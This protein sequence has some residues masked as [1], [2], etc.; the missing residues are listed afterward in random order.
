M[1]TKRIFLM[2]FS[3]IFLFAAGAYAQ[4]PFWAMYEG[5]FWEYSGTCSP[6]CAAWAWHNEVMAIDTTTVPGVTTYRL[7]GN[8]IGFPVTERNWFEI[9]PNDLKGWRLEYFDD[10]HGLITIKPNTGY[11][12]MKNPM[13]VPSNWSDFTAGTVTIGGTDYQGISITSTVNVSSYENVTVPLG[14]YKAYK[15]QHVLSVLGLGIM[16]TQ[17]LWVVPHLGIV[18]MTALQPSGSTEIKTLTSMR[19]RK[20]IFDQ[21]SDARTDIAIYQ[22]STGVWY[23][24]PSSGAPAYGVGWGGPGFTPVPGDYDGDGKTDVAIYQPTTGAW[25]IIPSSGAPGYGVGWGGPGFTPVPGDYDGDGKTDV[26]IYQAATGAWSIIPSSGAPAFGISWGGPE[27][28]PVPG[29]YDGDGK[30]DVAIY[31]T[32]TGVW[33]IIPSSGTGAFGVGWGGFASDILPITPLTAIN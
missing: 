29:D 30:I 19:I 20:S 32:T 14:T 21:D 4:A 22:P 9:G 27:F 10:A 18:R 1:K 17:D 13:I 7:D 6:P 15:L 2:N 26:A 3:L 5:N 25:Y 12:I 33:Y 23:I 28:I 16:R 11:T 24:K 31:Q 8:E